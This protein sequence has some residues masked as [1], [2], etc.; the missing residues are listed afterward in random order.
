MYLA[1]QLEFPI[2]IICN[3]YDTLFSSCSTAACV[4]MIWTIQDCHGNKLLVLLVYY[5]VCCV[6]FHDLFVGGSLICGA[7]CNSFRPCEANTDRKCSLVHGWG[8]SPARTHSSLVP[9]SQNSWTWARPRDLNFSTMDCSL[10][11]LAFSSS[12][13]S[14]LNWTWKGVTWKLQ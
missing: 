2:Y 13:I 14:R 12:R 10:A 3:I 9:W 6:W 7:V 4:L 5:H 8:V 1:G 11:V